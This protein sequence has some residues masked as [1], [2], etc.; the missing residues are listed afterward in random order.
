[1]VYANGTVYE[2]MWHLSVPHGAGTVVLHDGTR[3]EG[4]WREG[5]RHQG[6]QDYP[7][8]RRYTGEWQADKPHG[9][10][11]M[12]VHASG[13]H[14]WAAADRVPGVRLASGC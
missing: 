6:Q 3:F 8:G 5:L 14:P 4:E 12:V 1:M 11:V 9:Q 13:S 7:S 2:G 10:G